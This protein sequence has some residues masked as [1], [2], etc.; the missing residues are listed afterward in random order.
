MLKGH[1]SFKCNISG[2]K[3]LSLTPVVCSRADYPEVSSIQVETSS[4]RILMIT[5]RFDQIPTVEDAEIFGRVVAED[6][7]N[8]VAFQFAIKLG[9][10]VPDGNS[11][12]DIPPRR[13]AEGQILRSVGK[14]LT[15]RWNTGLP[16][17]VTPLAADCAALNSFLSSAQPRMD[18][19][20]QRFRW[21][22]DHDDPVAK[23]IHLYGVILKLGGVAP[24]YPQS[25]FDDFIRE[26]A[27]KMSP[28][29]VVPE[30]PKT[31][32]KSKGSETIFTKLRNQVGHVIDGSTPQ[33][34]RQEMIQ[35][36]DQLIT[37]AKIAIETKA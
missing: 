19:W 7:A 8:R 30:F 1:V 18:I 5:V 9:E 33:S 14:S 31:K 4:D 29:V 20:H 28:P 34:T 35:Y 15:T 32:P 36:L 13:S 37:F 27:A 10:V 2:S 26:E 23:F 25:G 6:T 3:L 12:E 22:M 17:T 21:I 24:D 11:F 16:Q